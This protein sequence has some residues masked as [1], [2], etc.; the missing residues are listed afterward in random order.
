MDLMAVCKP[1]SIP[2]HPCGGY[3]F[4]SLEYI[5]RYEPLIE[6]QPPLYLV[7]RLDRVTSG[8]V[9]LAKSTDAAAKISQEI[10]DKST[11]KVF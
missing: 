2:M 9:I 4:N 11:A 3:K 8:L 7:H 1:A 6:N 10:R 5:L